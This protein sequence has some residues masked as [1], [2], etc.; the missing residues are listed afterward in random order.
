MAIDT[1]EKRKS[2]SFLTNIV[3]GVTSNATKDAEWRAES[4]Y[5]YA[6]AGVT[7]VTFYALL[8]YLNVSLPGQIRTLRVAGA[9]LSLKLFRG[10]LTMVVPIIPYLEVKL[11]RLVVDL[12]LPEIT[13]T[14]QSNT[15]YGARATRA[16]N[17]RVTRA[18][19]LRATRYLINSYPEVVTLKL[20]DGVIEIQVLATS[21]RK[22]APWLPSL[23]K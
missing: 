11:P 12:L 15:I 5:G 9:N 21:G 2:I 16:G 22:R 3:P 10:V 6:R 13:G 7:V 4:G 1:A 23:R 20:D 18:G 19:N 17:P 8:P 14:R